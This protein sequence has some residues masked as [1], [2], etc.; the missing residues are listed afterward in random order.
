[1]YFGERQIIMSC[2]MSDKVFILIQVT[3]DVLVLV[4]V[5]IQHNDY[6][7]DVCFVNSLF[8]LVIKAL[9]NCGSKGN[10]VQVI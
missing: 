4:Y 10:Q 6:V 9:D 8:V 5:M 7:N 3:V 2:A 1:M